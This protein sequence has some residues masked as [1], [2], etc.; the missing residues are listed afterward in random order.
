MTRAR[1][2]VVGIAVTLAVASAVAAASTPSVTITS[3]KAGSTISAKKTPSLAVA[4]S[5]AFAS[6][7]PGSTTF[8]LRRDDCGG[9][10]N[11]RLSVVKGDP[12]GGDG[13]GLIVNAVVGLGGD[14][15]QAAFVD[16]PAVDGLPLAF[17][18]GRQITGVIDLA[19]LGLGA[20]EV[21][22]SMEALVN[23]EGVPIGSDS[24]TAVLDPT[25]NDNPVP[26]TIQPNAALAGADLQGVD[27]RVHIH[28]PQIYSGFIGLSGKS[29]VDV[30]SFTASTARG[31]Q[32]SL[33]DATFANPIA[34]SLSPSATG[35]SITVQTP[36][37]GK[38]TVYARAT[39]GY[40]TSAAAS[41]TF[42][43]KR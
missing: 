1:A 41:S 22:V 19:G 35:W 37:V 13:C 11:P 2:L 24:E 5:A 20:A 12:D 34:A 43:V 4:G 32:V 8:Y 30:P 16:F 15:D 25:A 21:D 33:D 14:V 10:D 6:V 26:F 36:A 29:Y 27:L 7:S 39:Q 42:T 9:N 23:G 17:D 40:D 3:P 28:G 31:V 38:H 18:A